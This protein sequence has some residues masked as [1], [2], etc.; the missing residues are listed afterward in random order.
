MCDSG[1]RLTSVLYIKSQVFGQSRLETRNIN[2]MGNKRQR[3]SRPGK[4]RADAE[5]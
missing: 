1:A 3:E 5:I 2:I 4:K